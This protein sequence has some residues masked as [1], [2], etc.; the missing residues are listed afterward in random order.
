MLAPLALHSQPKGV[1]LVTKYCPASPVF[2]PL[3]NRGAGSA[4][5]SVW[6]Y[7][8]GG[9]RPCSGGLL[10]G[11]RCQGWRRRGNVPSAPLLTATPVSSKIPRSACS[12]RLCLSASASPAPHDPDRA[13]HPAAPTASLPRRAAVP[14]S[15]RADISH[16]P[17]STSP[18]SALPG[19][20]HIAT[21][22]C[23]A[24]PPED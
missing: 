8:K 22:G 18:I 2:H 21:R 4:G 17:A 24:P 5:T 14:A 1:K 6:A 13:G 16:R 20:C 15:P 10:P 12:T 9:L 7:R 19:H 11:T 23:C 3:A